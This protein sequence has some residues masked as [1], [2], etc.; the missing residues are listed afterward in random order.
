M[1]LRHNILP[2]LLL[3]CCICLKS[4]DASIGTETLEFIDGRTA[5]SR[6]GYYSL[7]WHDASA[8]DSSGFYELE[9]ASTASFE[10]A[11][12]VYRGRDTAVFVSGLVDGSYFYRVR[13]AVQGRHGPWSAPFILT[14]KHGPI[15]VAWLLFAIGAVI[16][17]AIIAVVINGSRG[18]SAN[19]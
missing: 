8:R 16:F 14:V 17:L 1:T 13:T 2:K 6:E 9:R 7:R 12:A 4:A 18:T 3:L 10:G 5:V 11:K 19:G 15:A